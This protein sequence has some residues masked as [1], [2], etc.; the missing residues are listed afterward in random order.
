[1][2]EQPFSGEPGDGSAPERE[3]GGAA[4]QQGGKLIPLRAAD[5]GSAVAFDEKTEGPSYIDTTEIGGQ[6]REIIPEHLTR[7]HLPETLGAWLGRVRYQLLF[8]G[9]RS[10]WYVLWLTWLAH[11]GVRKLAGQLISWADATHLRL[12]ESEAVA[13]GRS[14]HHEAMRA[15][16]EGE[17]TRAR[18]WKIIGFSAVL[19]AVS[20]LAVWYFSRWWGL[21]ALGAIA[22]PVLV[23]HGRPYGKPIIEPAI[24]PEAYTIPTPEIIT[25]ALGSLNISAINKV[26]D[27]GAG[28][29]WVS[30]VHRDGEGWGVEF[31]LPYGVTAGDIIRRR[32]ELSSGLRRPLSAVWPEAVPGEHEGRVYLWIGR[33][34]LAKAK[35]PAYP[36]LKAGQ[37]DIFDHVPFATV[38]RGTGVSAPM[39]EAN[40][41]VGAAMGNGKTGTLR[42]LLAGAALD[43]ICDL[44][45]HEFSGKG[46]L[47][48]FAQVS[49]R[50]C[51]GMD[52]ESIAYAAESARM[53][54]AE[55][56]KRQKIF[57]A[58]PREVR[59]DGKLT[60]EMARDR[61][62][63]PIVASFDEFQV[64]IQH[65]E[66]GNQ[67]AAD[68]AHVMRLGRAYGIIILLATQR[69]DKESVP[70]AISGVVVIRFCLKVPDQVGNDL[71]LGT[72]AYKAGFNAV[73]F[74]HEIDAGL[75]WLRGT[76]D[77]QA[78]RTY[79]LDLNAS[80]KIAARARAMRRAA[81]VLSGYA[82]GEDAGE[83]DRS[84]A[85][86]ALSVFGTDAKLWCTTI[87]ARLRDRI[88]GVYADITPVAVGSQLREIGVTVKNV[89]EPG[90]VPNLG[91]E[92]SAL[93][94]ITDERAASAPDL[95]AGTADPA[96]FPGGVLGGGEPDDGKLLSGPPAG[97]LP[98]DFPE[99]LVQSAGIV[100]STQFGSTSMLQRKLR[101]GFTAAGRL[102]DELE[103]W[104]IV[105]P[106]EGTKARD[107]L[108]SAD[109][110]DEALASLRGGLGA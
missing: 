10:P 31:D 61:R 92:R 91:C 101:I 79:Y 89:R 51:S 6:R 110:L 4:G 23:W 85:A 63:R 67:I 26:I 55:L 88:P 103:S 56:V 93:D 50:Y 69:P 45:T 78:V 73:I 82:L 107:V 15:H 13:V 72:G 102:M 104:G 68:L 84:F 49:H 39:F 58:L 47:E 75:G 80:A 96:V 83:D 41:L 27:S 22:Y 29:A 106:P 54:K 53:L 38:P 43:P 86:D 28:I 108:V 36:L 30:D 32:K 14:A 17:K 2:A 34:D 97:D 87:A 18:H 42:V 100:I 33:H 48:P 90:Q 7:A 94:A 16:T 44:W 59:P 62:L 66:H 37:A 12:L 81:G 19:V 64:A 99:L 1:M 77:P 9:F 25:R 3:G 20:L 46:D 60:R 52:D 5:A 70:T 105:G 65:P 98:D 40:W 57:K 24:L 76:G 109:D 95:S 71:I 35:P 11:K 21:I 8:H 74:R